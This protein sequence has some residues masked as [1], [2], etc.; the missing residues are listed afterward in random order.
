[1]NKTAI[2]S[3][4]EGTIQ[5]LKNQKADVKECSIVSKSSEEQ[6]NVGC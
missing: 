4:L 2:I 1:M 3:M 6:N 5:Q